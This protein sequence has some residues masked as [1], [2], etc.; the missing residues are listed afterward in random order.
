MI[1]IK[2]IL[3]FYFITIWLISNKYKTGVYST[4]YKFV[5]NALLL[6][7]S[8]P[9]SSDCIECFPASLN[10]IASQVMAFL[11]ALVHPIRLVFPSFSRNLLNTLVTIQK[12][13]CNGFL[14]S[15]K[16][17]FDMLSNEQLLASFDTSSIKY[18]HLG[19]QIVPPYLVQK[20]FEKFNLEYILILYGMSES[21]ISCQYRIDSSTFKQFTS[22]RYPVGRP[23]PHFEFKVV[24]LKDDQTIVSINTPGELLLK[25][26]T[27][28]NGYWNDDDKTREA[29]SS[30]GW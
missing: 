24:D 18:I 20:S 15:P 4:F 27:I 30:D 11:K 12:H 7:A 3:T 13:R 14:A 19:S 6:V 25:S 22:E 9:Q 1:F 28:F 29:L 26:F 10:F 8:N 16:F 2:I 21:L 5:N 17:I 23:I